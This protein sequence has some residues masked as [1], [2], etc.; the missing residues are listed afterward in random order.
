[1]IENFLK[2]SYLQTP[3]LSKHKKIML[4]DMAVKAHE[5]DDTR[6]VKYYFKLFLYRLNGEHLIEKE[7]E[8]FFKEVI[9]V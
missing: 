3:L 4:V 6:P 8:E 9:D 1:M 5:I 7:K 2:P